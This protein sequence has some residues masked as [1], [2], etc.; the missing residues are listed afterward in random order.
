MRLAAWSF[1]DSEID[2][3]NSEQSSSRHGHNEFSDWTREEWK[4]QADWK[5]HVKR[6][7]TKRY[8]EVK[9]ENEILPTSFFWSS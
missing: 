4:N 6:P 3:H 7:E 5:A 2:R 9:H 8:Q 1:I